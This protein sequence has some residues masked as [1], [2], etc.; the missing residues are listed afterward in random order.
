[1]NHYLNKEIYVLYCLLTYIMIQINN[2]IL[3]IIDIY[4]SIYYKKIVDT[5]AFTPFEINL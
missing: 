4:A 3:L 1:M 5:Y 2:F